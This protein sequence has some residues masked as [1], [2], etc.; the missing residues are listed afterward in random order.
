MRAHF[1][2][3]SETPGK[4]PEGRRQRPEALPGGKLPAAARPS[5]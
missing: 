3:G 2:G 1:P 5:E 4:S